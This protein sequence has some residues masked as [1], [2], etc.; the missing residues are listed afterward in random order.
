MAK[1]NKNVR[2]RVN[3]IK[4]IIKIFRTMEIS[5]QVLVNKVSKKR[6]KP[7]KIQQRLQN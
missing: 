4:G 5:R 7:K 6:F 3:K 1:K 2:I